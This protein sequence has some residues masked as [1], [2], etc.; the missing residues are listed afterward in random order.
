MKPFL[1]KFA[2][3]EDKPNDLATR[4]TEYA[5]Q[6]EILIYK[7]TSNIEPVMDDMSFFRGT[8]TT[9]TFAHQ[10]PSQ[11]EDGDR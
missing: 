8:G 9:M 11:D 4:V 6:Q 1:M 5:I 3:P 2:R 10:D 7:D